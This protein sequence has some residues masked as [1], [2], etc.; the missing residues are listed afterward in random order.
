MIQKE[1]KHYRTIINYRDYISDIRLKEMTY[2]LPVGK[3]SKKQKHLSIIQKIYHIYLYLPVIFG[4]TTNPS[5]L[6][7]L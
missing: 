4:I 5:K 7:S 3:I 2:S 1:S 6:V